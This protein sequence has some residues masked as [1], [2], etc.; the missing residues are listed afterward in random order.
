M[1]NLRTTLLVAGLQIG[2]L[3]TAG[4][5]LAQ[6][7]VKGGKPQEPAA[8]APTTQTIDQH[9]T[10]LGSDSYRVRLQ[11]ESSLRK[12]GKDALPALRKAA[13]QSK[14]NEVQWRA[15]RLVRQIEHGDEQGLVERS[16]VDAQDD[17]APSPRIGAGRR[18]LLDEVHGQFDSLFERFERDLGL[19]V[20]RA[21]FF[22][23]DFFRDLQDQIK[24]G[25]GTS[26][27][28]VVRIDSSGA[29]HVEVNETNEKGET[30][31]KVYDAPDLDSFRQ[32]YPGVLQRN[33]LSLGLR[34]LG[35]NPFFAAPNLR[36]WNWDFS[37]PD[38]A[39]QPWTPAPGAPD[40]RATPPED[41]APPAGKR[42]GVYVHP[43]IPAELRLH[44]G[45][46]DD[47]GLMVE[48]VQPDSL[49]SALGLERGDIVTAIGD[50]T[51]GSTQD[52]QDA[53]GGIEAGQT[54]KVQFLRKGA[55]QTASA[56]KPETEAPKAEKLEPRRKA[57]TTIR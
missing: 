33:G 44:L 53:L 47:V 49:A 23:D 34:P 12:L 43:N 41:A 29:V 1:K 35:N 45:L 32:Q 13:D 21:H 20:P 57:S 7:P 27:G 22:Q 17:G 9:I 28:M 3:G 19:D 18:N 56:K 38:A 31:K 50:H 51:I 10:D 54:V 37:Q 11:A 4:W 39:L 26:Q 24:A 5:L 15:R 25:K 42:L 8:A 16:K 30:E 52:V 14:D 6:D 46:A 2:G 55:T 40:V 48:S 36:A